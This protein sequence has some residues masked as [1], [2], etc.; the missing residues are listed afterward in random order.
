LGPASALQGRK[1]QSIVVPYRPA[2][3]PRVH[4]FGECYGG[5]R[6]LELARDPAR[7]SEMAEREGPASEIFAKDGRVGK[8]NMFGVT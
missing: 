1:T 2:P 5:E 8:S 3:P 4:L 7:A 6:F